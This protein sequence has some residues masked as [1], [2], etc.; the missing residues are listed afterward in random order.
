VNPLEVRRLQPGDTEAFLS[1]VDA[2]ADFEGMPRPSPE[3]RARLIEHALMDPP[4]QRSYVALMEGEVVGY[5][6]VFLAYSSFLARPT[7]FIEDIFIRAT[8]RG[9]GV[10]TTF[11]A[12]LADEARSLAC[13]RIEWMVQH[14]NE[15]AQ[16]FY[17]RQGAYPLSD[18]QPWR[19]DP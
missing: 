19:L 3:A 15:S 5:A 17:A 8:H 2:H 4:L 11:M 6:I 7:F 13:G 10:G 12:A 9:Q 18:W 14:W 16:R 1:L